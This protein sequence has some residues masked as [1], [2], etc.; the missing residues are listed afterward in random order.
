MKLSTFAFKNAKNIKSILTQRNV[1]LWYFQ[2]D[3]RVH[4]FQGKKNTKP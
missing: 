4:N 3:L 1:P 2:D